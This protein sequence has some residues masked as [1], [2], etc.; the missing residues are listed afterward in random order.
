MFANRDANHIQE[1]K[2]TVE[3]PACL[4]FTLECGALCEQRGAM[5]RLGV[6]GVRASK[7]MIGVSPI[8]DGRVQ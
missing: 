7:S 2:G 8:G 3:S 6:V 4:Q 5:D 1:F